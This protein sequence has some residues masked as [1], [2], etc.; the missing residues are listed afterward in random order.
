MSR[1]A[2]KAVLSEAFVTGD[3][4]LGK[5]MP[6]RLPGRQ[7]LAMCAIPRLSLPYAR[8]CHCLPAVSDRW[9]QT[10][11]LLY[12]SR[13]CVPGSS[14]Q[15][16][17][18]SE[19]D[20]LRLVQPFRLFIVNILYYF[21]KLNYVYSGEYDA[22]YMSRNR[23]RSWNETSFTMQAQARNAPQHPQAPKMIYISPSKRT[24]AKGCE[25]LYRR[26][27]VRE[28]ARIQTFPDT[29]K[30]IYHDVKDGYKMVGNAVP[31]RLAWYIAIQIKK[32]FANQMPI[33]KA[34]NQVKQ[35]IKQVSVTKIAEQYSKNIVNNTN[36]A[37]V[38]DITGI[39]IDKR[40]LI[41]LVRPD[42][43]EHY[44]DHSAK[45]Y[46]TGKNFPST[47]ALNKLYY[48]MPYIKGKGVRD[49]YLIKIARVGTKQEVHPECDD[50]DFR[51]VFEIQYIKQLF[52]SHKP[53]HLNIWRTFTDMAMESLLLM[54]EH[55]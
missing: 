38:K 53:V 13:D 19:S 12:R 7:Y 32:S 54:N 40:V 21:R 4:V 1:P 42:N 16:Q 51:L 52:E 10:V 35:T 41:S 28:C 29:F 46:Y 25:H 17:I 15:A 6:I 9:F 49:L 27:S 43:V 31:P 5:S 20:T 3:E 36:L 14:P 34:E 55:G 37:S 23:V 11:V 30:F 18:A 33:S 24:F 48:F 39:E 22:K 47:I 44:I 8:Y 50:N 2:W 45:I 26:L